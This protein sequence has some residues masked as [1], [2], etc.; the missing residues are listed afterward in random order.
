MTETSETAKII[1]VLYWGLEYNSSH[2]RSMA[3][4]STK[5]IFAVLDVSLIMGLTLVKLI[6]F[7]TLIPF[8]SHSSS[9]VQYSKWPIYKEKETLSVQ[10]IQDPKIKEVGHVSLTTPFLTLKCYF[11]RI[12]SVY[13]THRISIL[14]VD[15][16][17]TKWQKQSAQAILIVKLAL[18]MCPITVPVSKGSKITIYFE[19]PTHFAYSLFNFYGATMTI[20]GSLLMSVPIVKRFFG[21]RMRRIT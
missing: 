2:I 13:I 12:T 3:Q 10:K 1:L 20:K 11:C 6:K 19:P 7:L 5:M 15:R 16:I 9:T 4:Y 21:M 14:Y 18:S 8:R 17:T